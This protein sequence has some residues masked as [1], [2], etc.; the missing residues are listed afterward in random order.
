MN[1]LLS[2]REDLLDVTSLTYE[3]E[4]MSL[5]EVTFQIYVNKNGNHLF[6]VYCVSNTVLSTL[7]V[8]FVLNT[9]VFNQGP[10]H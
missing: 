9:H 6:S 4:N 5:S 7:Y 10:S 2:G 8:H 1:L 3:S